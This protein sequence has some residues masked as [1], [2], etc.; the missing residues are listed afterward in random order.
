VKPQAA[1]LLEA[2]VASRPTSWP[3]PLYLT[4][5]QAIQFTGLGE[6]ELRR[7][8]KGLPRGPRGALVYRRKDLEA[9]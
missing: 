8:A 5:E 9:L 4:L 7:C 1:A 3:P 6:S 2:L